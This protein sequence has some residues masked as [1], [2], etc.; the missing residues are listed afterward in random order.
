MTV[1]I[2]Y[3]KKMLQL[4]DIL[5]GWA[6]FDFGGMIGRGGRSCRRNRVAKDFQRRK[7]KNTFVKING[8]TIGVQSSEKSL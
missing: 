8:E 2:Y 4:F 3:A 6:K 5:R 1:K 7:C